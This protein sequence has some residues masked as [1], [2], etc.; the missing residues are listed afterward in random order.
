MKVTRILLA[1]IFI[2]TVLGESYGF[3]NQRY[4]WWKLRL[5]NLDQEKE[6]LQEDAKYDKSVIELINE[7]TERAKKMLVAFEPGSGESGS[8]DYQKR[9]Y[10]AAEIDDKITGIVLSLFSENYLAYMVR[11]IGEREHYEHAV[12]IV[13]IYLDNK[14]RT[15]FRDSNK[16]FQQDIT[17][18]YISKTDWKYLSMEVFLNRLIS[19]K[20]RLSAYLKSDIEKEVLQHLSGNYAASPGE[21]QNI[22]ISVTAEKIRKFNIGSSLDYSLDALNDSWCWRDIDVRISRY[23][24]LLKEIILLLDDPG[25]P[26]PD[27]RQLCINTSELERIYFSKLRAVH[28]NG[29]SIPGAAEKQNG[30]KAGSGEDVYIINIPEVPQ[31]DKLYLSMDNLRSK[32][33]SVINGSEQTSYFSEITQSAD[34][35]IADGI[36]RTGSGFINEQEKLRKAR[37]EWIKENAPASFDLDSHIA[38]EVETGDGA[39]KF[40]AVNEDAFNKA[41]ENF[42]DNSQ[43]LEKYKDGMLA[44]LKLLTRIRMR[45]DIEADKSYADKINQF[46]KYIKFAGGIA[47]DYYRNAVVPLFNSDKFG[48]S[49]RGLDKL[50]KFIGYSIGFNI[51]TERLNN[52][53]KKGLECKRD[54]LIDLMKSEESRLRKIYSDLAKKQQE[55]SLVFNTKNK[56]IQ[57]DIAELE[58]ELLYDKIKDYFKAFERYTYARKALEDY[59]S[60]YEDFVDEIN[61][62]ECSTLLKSVLKQESMLNAVRGFDRE[63]IAREYEIK[64]YLKVDITRDMARLYTLLSFYKSKCV[65]IRNK[66]VQDEVNAMKL[67]LGERIEVKI[68]GW[69]M[70]EVNI[71]TIDYKAVKKLSMSYDKSS[72]LG[73]SEETDSSQEKVK[74][75]NM[76]I[77][78]AVPGGWK[79]EDLM[80]GDTD[81]GILKSFRNNDRSSAIYIA[82][83]NTA[84]KSEEEISDQWINKMGGS[85]VLKKWGRKDNT[86][87][88]WSLSRRKSGEVMESYVIK[89]GN[90]A[91]IFSGTS[92]ADKYSLFKK[93][94]S[95]VFNSLS[96]S[97]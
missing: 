83:L 67:R 1:L 6:R 86:D 60:R 30:I 4:E 73:D 46:E 17:R 91:L 80:T 69:T 7:D 21:L 25:I 22:I 65:D 38:G 62:G 84:G 63:R 39:I 82:Q 75:K 3:I 81:K 97:I 34:N 13:R 54:E 41:W 87:Y 43:H 16:E 53:Q 26:L 71:D 28:A 57:Q 77:S 5:K 12:E 50:Y 11:N 79:E 64:R 96:T 31:Y 61:G 49:V 33:S 47:D 58:I 15:Y 56:E 94:M 2:F 78:F 37:E 44:F 92:S 74:L 20:T 93:K 32:N 42:R 27:A 76:E 23:F 70:N 89:Q 40:H 51:E 35:I 36:S 48:I 19:N 45:N 8:A 88:L 68:S 10:T 55:K 52:D 72:W 14:I 59:S 95:S 29:I 24:Q 18:D 9:K 66:P 90:T 85:R